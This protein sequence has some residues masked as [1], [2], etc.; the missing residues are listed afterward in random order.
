MRAVTFQ[1]P[2]EVRI[3]EKPDPELEGP[4]D[5]IV[6]VD[7]SGVCGSD[8]HIYHGRVA[9]EPGFTIGHEYVGEVVAVGDDVTRV[10]AG[11]RVLGTYGT[12]CGECFFCL[13]EDFHKCDN[14]RVFGHGKLLG[15]LQGA[16]A[17]LLLVPTA[18]IALRK[19]PEG[20]SDDIALFAGDVMGTGY[21][22]VAETGVGAGDTVAVLGLGPVGLCAVQAAKAAGAETVI[23][24]DTVADR[25]EMARAF[26]AEPCHLTEE[27]PRAAAKAATEG[28]G[29]DAAIDAVGHPEA[30]DLACRLTRKCGTVSA[31]GVYAERMEVHMGVVWIKAL[32]VKTGHANVIKHVDPVLDALSS[33]RLDPSP[34]VTHHMK[35]DDAAEAYDIYDRR[36][37][38][39]IVLTP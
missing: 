15:E 32:T 36:E 12:A 24:I 35:L 39:K 13:R 27:D 14:G 23:A 33:G 5:A 30:F 37:A 18:D 29:V 20:M 21:H 38:L 17:E 6:R 8:L 10:S 26:G 31:T 7:A 9:I 2:G 11:D 1:A 3:D 19:V 22:A 34:L 16:Q 25:L 28:R 4:G